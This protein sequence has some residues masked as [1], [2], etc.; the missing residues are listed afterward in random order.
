MTHGIMI[1]ASSRVE[2]INA[3]SR[4]I[5]IATVDR[6]AQTRRADDLPTSA[7]NRS[8]APS[9]RFVRAFRMSAV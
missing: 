2:R 9:W 4:N 8:C 6:V 5:G 1:G 3:A 7:R